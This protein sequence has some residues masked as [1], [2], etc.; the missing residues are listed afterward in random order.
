MCFLI[1]YHFLNGV[2][3]SFEKSLQTLLKVLADT[4]K[5]N[6]PIKERRIEQKMYLCNASAVKIAGVYIRKRFLLYPKIEIAKF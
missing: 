3:I 1:D 5:K 2:L 4:F 6:S